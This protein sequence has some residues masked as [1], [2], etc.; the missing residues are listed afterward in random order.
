ME[1]IQ[2]QLIK[3]LLIGKKN[4]EGVN[5]DKTKKEAINNNNLSIESD[6][7]TGALISKLIGTNSSNV[8]IDSIYFS[9]F[10][11]IFF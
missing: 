2:Q 8:R 10:K 4:N 3:N 6:T 5:E 1:C 7:D 11:F 9:G